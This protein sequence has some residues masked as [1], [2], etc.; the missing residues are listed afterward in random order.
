[1]VLDED[2]ID[3]APQ[4]SEE[5]GSQIID[6]AD[7]ICEAHHHVGNGEPKDNCKNPC[8][9][10]TLYRLLGRELNELRAAKG[11]AADVSEYIVRDDQRC[12]QQTPD[13]AFKDVIY[14][15]MGLHDDQVERDV[16]PAELGELE[17]VVAF[18]QR[19]YEE[20]EA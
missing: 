19:A 17:S 3:L 8:T 14:D 15:K 20:D 16:R 10:K 13:H 9:D 4:A 12:R 11:D 1:V 5:I 2:R 6:R 7:E 18:L